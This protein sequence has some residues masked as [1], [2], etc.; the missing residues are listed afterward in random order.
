MPDR[1]LNRL[2]G[3]LHQ[4]GPINPPRATHRDA[5]ENDL[6][7]GFRKQRSH[8]RRWLMLLNPWNRTARFALVGLAL[9]TLGL[10]A[11]TTSTTTEVPMG[12]KLTISVTDKAEQD[13]AALDA[14]LTAFLDAQADIESVGIQLS[15]TVGG[16]VV[17][18]VVAWG[19][20]LDAN[21]LLADLRRAIPALAEVDIHLE[22]LT[23]TMEES[24]AEKLRREIF[25]IEI[26]GG[27]AE[28]IR[29]QIM[30]QL[31]EQGVAEN[32]VVEVK[33]G[34]GET[35]ITITVEEDTGD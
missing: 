20:N 35:D 11:C 8:N 28:E 14:E 31:A 19:A 32:A 10:G 22:A 6:L 18:D 13:I 9:L 21:Q 2:L 23:G 4:T 7:Q 17:F 15:E 3:R 5:L 25:Q 1:R 34:D 27:T 12:Q 30:A 29:A 24:Y 33:M 16:S 26:D